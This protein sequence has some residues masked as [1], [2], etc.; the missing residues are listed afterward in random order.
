MVDK[1]NESEFLGSEHEG[2]K[3]VDVR[4]N[5]FKFQDHLL[6]WIGRAS[7][8]F[9]NHEW[10]SSFDAITIVYLD[11]IGFLDKEEIEELDELWEAAR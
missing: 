7:T 10:N 4:Y 3:K 6:Y 1:Y 9:V 5:I 8:T 11:T 2:K